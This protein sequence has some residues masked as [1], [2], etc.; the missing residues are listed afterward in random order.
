[1]KKT[2]PGHT[3]LFIHTDI[4]SSK[5]DIQYI[6]K[7]FSCK[8]SMQQSSV[9][10]NKIYLNMKGGWGGVSELDSIAETFKNIARHKMG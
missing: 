10:I 8:Y 3:G 1:M 2:N 5:H 4:D 6:M 9:R 7:I